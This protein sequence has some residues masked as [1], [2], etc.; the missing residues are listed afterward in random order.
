M[1]ITTDRLILREASLEIT[2]SELAFL[3][4]ET[5]Q[6]PFAQRLG[7]HISTWPPNLH[8]ATSC[9]YTLDKLMQNPAQ[10]GWS[11]WYILLK[12]D[13]EIPVLV[14]GSG[15]HAPPDTDG[16]VEIGY[17][18]VNAYQR[19]GIAPE[20]VRALTAWAFDHEQVNRIIITTLD[21]PDFVPSTKVALKCG[22]HFAGTKDDPQEG[23]LLV[24]E[25]YR[26]EFN[27][28]KLSTGSI[29]EP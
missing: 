11:M 3:K 17:G 14:G 7:A 2:T 1:S 27:K 29:H 24:Y 15:F 22:F 25:L 28:P 18:V 23:T 10:I 8:D 19:M 9:A 13:D 21:S 5:S 12:R 6:K 16:N 26:N 20:A 4:G